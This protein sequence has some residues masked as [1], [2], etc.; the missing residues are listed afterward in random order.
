MAHLDA[1]ISSMKGFVISG[2]EST[3]VVKKCSLSVLKVV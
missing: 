1:S 3:G 2:I